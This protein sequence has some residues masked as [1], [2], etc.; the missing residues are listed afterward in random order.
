[1]NSQPE[2]TVRITLV[3]EGISTFNLHSMQSSLRKLKEL[4]SDVI[5]LE[6]PHCE[7]THSSRGKPFTQKT[8]HHH[9]RKRHPEGENK[10]TK[11]DNV[12]TCEICGCWKSRRGT[13]FMTDLELSYHRRTAHRAIPSASQNEPAGNPVKEV[14]TRSKARQQIVSSPVKF[15]PQCGCNVEVVAAALSIFV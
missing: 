3:T 6:C 11:P 8:L 10:E 14:E 9:I 2:I 5:Q 4:K 15:C 7:V 13:P 12:L 1:M